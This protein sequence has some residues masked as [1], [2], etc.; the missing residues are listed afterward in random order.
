MYVKA[1][2]IVG[3]LEH[4]MWD[5]CFLELDALIIWLNLVKKRQR[6]TFQGLDKGFAVFGGAK[7]EDSVCHP[8]T[9]SCVYHSQQGFAC[10]R[11]ERFQPCSWQ[12]CL[13]ILCYEPAQAKTLTDL[14][15]LLG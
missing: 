11:V 7:A 5:H 9:I 2:Q 12:R 10:K 14:F 6:S 8:G 15:L 4:E 13:N 1:F 3:Q